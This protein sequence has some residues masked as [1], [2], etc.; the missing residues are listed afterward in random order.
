MF[1]LPLETLGMTSLC[2]GL[3]A[4]FLV[5]ICVYVIRLMI[6]STS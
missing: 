6:D 4:R 5:A 2:F 1:S 3:T